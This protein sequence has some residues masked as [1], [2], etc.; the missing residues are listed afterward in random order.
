MVNSTQALAIY[1][2]KLCASASALKATQLWDQRQQQF[3]T[4]YRICSKSVVTR[5]Q[6]LA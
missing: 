2:R 3:F 4:L 5:E 1:D 6:K